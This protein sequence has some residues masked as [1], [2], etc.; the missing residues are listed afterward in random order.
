VGGITDARAIT[1]A[2]KFTVEEA[3]DARVKVEAWAEK[4]G[5][6]A[7]MLAEKLAAQEAEAARARAGG[8]RRTM[9]ISWI[10]GWP[11]AHS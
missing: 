3:E 10:S 6:D 2:A 5:G 7:T 8:W 11:S 4:G 1:A 9:S